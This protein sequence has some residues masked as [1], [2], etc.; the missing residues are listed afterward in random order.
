MTLSIILYAKDRRI[1][2]Q[3]DRSLI[4][5]HSQGYVTGNYVSSLITPVSSRPAPRNGRYRWKIELVEEKENV[6]EMPCKTER[7]ENSGTLR[8]PVQ[9]DCSKAI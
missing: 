3:N 8:A 1:Y 5:W 6:A 7:I 2:S 4:S 9:D